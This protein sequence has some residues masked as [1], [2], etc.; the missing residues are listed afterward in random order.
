MRIAII[1]MS[2]PKVK[3]QGSMFDD[4]VEEEPL[5]VIPDIIHDPISGMIT[6]ISPELR[7]V[8]LRNLRRDRKQREN[9][10]KFRKNSIILR[11]EL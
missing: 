4:V 9:A 6:V 1:K 8:M 10:E 3:F 7:E 2:K 11:S 5:P